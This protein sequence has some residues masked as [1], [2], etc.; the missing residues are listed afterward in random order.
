MRGGTA[1]IVPVGLEL[2]SSAAFRRINLDHIPRG[3][4]QRCATGA[5]SPVIAGLD[6]AI[7]PLG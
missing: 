4:A 6:P 3:A 1:D 7:L 5:R 2:R